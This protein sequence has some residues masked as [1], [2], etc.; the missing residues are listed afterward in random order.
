MCTD[1]GE[2]LMA[3]ENEAKQVKPIP[4]IKP[5]VG[6]MVYYKSYG[7][8]NGEYKPQNRAAIVTDVHEL[9]GTI[10]VDE[11]SA[12]CVILNLLIVG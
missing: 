8:P 10:R 4:T 1:N 2:V 12:F 6:R 3:P 7:T 5:T 11:S 9:D